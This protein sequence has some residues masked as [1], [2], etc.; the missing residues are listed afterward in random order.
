M[1]SPLIWLSNAP[2][3]VIA[4]YSRDF[5]LLCGGNAEVMAPTAM[6]C[7]GPGTWVSVCAAFYLLPAAYEQR[8][9]NIAQALSAGLLPSE[10]FLYTAINDPEHTLFNWIASSVAV[11]DDCLDGSGGP[12]GASR[13]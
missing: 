12:G 4:S 8:W 9:V 6:R 5:V 11:A 7:G 1:C 2:A 3:G 13:G 10:N